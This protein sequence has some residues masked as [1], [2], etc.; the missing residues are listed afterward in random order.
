MNHGQPS[1]VVIP[2]IAATVTFYVLP[3]MLLL[4]IETEEATGGERCQVDQ[5]IQRLQVLIVQLASFNRSLRAETP[6]TPVCHV[7]GLVVVKHSLLGCRVIE[8]CSFSCSDFMVH[9][10]GLFCC[11]A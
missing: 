9:D 4:P 5:T 2:P 8:V 1:S 11:K 6:S 3:S 7:V 10:V